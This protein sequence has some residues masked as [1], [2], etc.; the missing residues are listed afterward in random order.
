[1]GRKSKW[2]DLETYTPHKSRSRAAKKGWATRRT[3]YGKKGRK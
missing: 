1:M 2:S 3:K